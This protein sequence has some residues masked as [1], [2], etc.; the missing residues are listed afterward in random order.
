MPRDRHRLRTEYPSLNA[1]VAVLN[2]IGWLGLVGCVVILFYWLFNIDE[3]GL[4]ISMVQ[5]FI[6]SLWSLGLAQLFVVFVA[7]D[8]SLEAI[9]QNRTESLSGRPA[10]WFFE[11]LDKSFSEIAEQIDQLRE[12]NARATIEAIEWLHE[13]QTG[14]A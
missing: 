7:I 1:L 2:I 13:K 5:L 12:S 9:K 14:K 11:R 3:V 6:A 4:I 8:G 10:E